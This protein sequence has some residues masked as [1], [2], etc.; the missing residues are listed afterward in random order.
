MIKDITIL[1]IGILIGSSIMNYYAQKKISKQ[2]TENVKSFQILT[3]LN[4]WLIM[5]QMNKNMSPY[6]EDMGYKEIA[7]YGMGILGQR[8]Y[9]ELED[10]S[11][12]VKYAID[13]NAANISDLTDVKHPSDELEEVDAVIVTSLYYYDEIKQTMSKKLQCP[14]ISIKDCLAPEFSKLN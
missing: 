3:F 11:V 9:D 8:L 13:Q 14:I 2:K 10:T 7:I 4:N 6:I 5:H 1:I 12:L